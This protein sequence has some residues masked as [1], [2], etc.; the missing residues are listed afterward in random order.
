MAA[1]VFTDEEMFKRRQQIRT[2]SSFL[3]ANSVENPA[4]QQ[5][6]KKGLS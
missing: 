2:R 4:L 6:G 5:Q 3:F 1:A